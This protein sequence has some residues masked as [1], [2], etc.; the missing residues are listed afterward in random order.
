MISAPSFSLLEKKTKQN[1]T[2]VA[3]EQLWD[4]YFFVILCYNIVIEKNNIMADEN[5]NILEQAKI[6]SSPGRGKIETS[7]PESVPDKIEKISTP[8]T[9]NFEREKVKTEIEKLKEGKTGQE[10]GGIVS[11]SNVG[12]KLSQRQKE[13]ESILSEGL[14]KMYL[15]MTPEKQQEFK[16]VGEETAQKINLLLSSAKVKMKRVI[17]L[18]RGWLSLLPGVNKFFLEQETKIR[19][20]K[21]TKLK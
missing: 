5:Q 7:V 12:Q 18:I 3:F 15:E 4:F 6:E 21:I 17:D 9:G 14:E 19:V 1:P 20:D 13:I 11:S 8:E 2:A 10:I 16:Q